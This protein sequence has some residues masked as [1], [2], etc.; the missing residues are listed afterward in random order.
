MHIGFDANSF[1]VGVAEGIDHLVLR[2]TYAEV[3]VDAVKHPG[4]SAAAR[5]FADEGG[6]L[7]HF[8]V[9]AE[10]LRR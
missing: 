3:V 2:D 4:M 10:L 7:E 9:V 8:Q 6:A 5:C 1:P